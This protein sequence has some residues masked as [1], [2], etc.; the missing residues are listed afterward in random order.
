M[1]ELQHHG[2]KGMHWG[3]R[4]DNHGLGTSRA[5]AKVLKT[6]EKSKL[7]QHLD[8]LKRERQ[9]HKT[10]SEMDKMNTSDIRVI[11]KRVQ[12]ENSLKRLSKARVGMTKIGTQKDKQDYLRRHEMSDQE[13]GRKIARLQAKENLVKAVKDASKEQREVGIKAVKAVGTIGLKAATG[14]KLKPKDFIDAY[15][16][17]S[18]NTKQEAWDKGIE[19][20][21][22]RVTNPKV[23]KALG[24]A[25]HVK[26]K[27]PK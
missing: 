16:K 12:A 5:E 6:S 7:R 27:Q 20:A 4:K 11:T 17:P 1:T 2:V 25:K 9:W 23:K 10:L 19:A 8:S 24:L 18:F 22:G 14:E 21:N 15:Q 3:R 13:L 26:F